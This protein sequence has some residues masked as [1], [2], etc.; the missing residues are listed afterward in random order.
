MLDKLASHIV[1]NTSPLTLS[2]FVS[3]V[4]RSFFDKRKASGFRAIVQYAYR[5][6]RF[7]R[8]KFD[9]FGIDPAKVKSPSDLGDFYTMPQDIVERAEDF[10]CQPAHMVFESSGTTGRNK[11][12]Y[13]TQQ[14]L[15]N[16]GQSSAI[17][18]FSF[19]INLSDRIV[20][21]FDFCIWIPGIVTQKGLDKLKVFCMA[22]GKVDPMEVYKRIP[23]YQFNVIMGEPT[24]L[25]K[26]TELAEKHG[27]YPLKML[28]GSAEAMPEAARPWIEKVWQGAKVRMMYGT[29]ESGGALGFEYRDVC[30]D[31][32][33]NENNFYV[34]I[35]NPDEDGYGEVVFTTLDRLTM[36]LIRYRNRD[37]SRLIEEPC[38]CGLSVRKLAKIRG[39]ADELVVASG[40]NLY[41]LMFEEILKD[42]PYISKDWRVVFRLDGIKEVMEFHLESLKNEPKTIEDAVY[43]N[44]RERYPDLWKNY[45]IEIF[46]IDFLYHA[47]GSLRT[48]RK[49]IRVIDNRHSKL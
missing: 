3:K 38:D 39:R 37:I 7:Y 44:I 22:A 29:V 8:E 16:I 35:F 4:P 28:I 31:Y 9:Q 36:P 47:P 6:S 25:I 2:R 41:P 30:G 18:L 23:T 15:D 49:L 21:A 48:G 1:L 5:H 11:R 45:S 10:I 43:S 13:F 46:R 12:V 33:I 34:E 27:S 42:V 20:N 19:G 40:G 17:G 32:H 24:W 14:E 26:L